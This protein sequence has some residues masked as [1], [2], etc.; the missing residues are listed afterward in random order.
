MDKIKI[1]ELFETL[2]NFGKNLPVFCVDFDIR[3]NNEDIETYLINTTPTTDWEGKPLSSDIIKKDIDNRISCFHNSKE[4]NANSKSIIT[5][6]KFFSL[7]DLQF[8]I[9]R[10]LVCGEEEYMPKN[11]EF[12]S[13]FKLSDISQKDNL[14]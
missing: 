1:L 14:A 8:E 5:M 4:Y 3:A 6:R 12:I 10:K 9:V 7:N 13:G 11:Y 2:V